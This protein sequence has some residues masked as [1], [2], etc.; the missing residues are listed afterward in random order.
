MS[1]HAIGHKNKRERLIGSEEAFGRYEREDTW[2]T[3]FFTK[4]N[5]R[6][7]LDIKD[8]TMYWEAFTDHDMT[9][10]LDW[11]HPDCFPELSGGGG[12]GLGVLNF[13]EMLTECGWTLD[14]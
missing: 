10:H 3:L 7:Q 14:D 6:G 13:V 4:G 11:N 12:R 2:Q 8:T 5:L 1:T 9:Q